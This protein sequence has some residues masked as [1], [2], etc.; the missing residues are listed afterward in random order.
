MPAA[1]SDCSV[2]VV[3][4]DSADVVGGCL[5]SIPAECEVVVVD[6]ASSDG[7]AR[8]AAR[9]RPD[10][11]L[12][13]MGANRGFAAGCNAGVGASTRPLVLL[14][15][16]D[17]RLEPDA[18]DT[19]CTALDRHPGAIVGPAVLDDAGRL[20]HAVRRPSAPLHEVL[21]LFP[22][23]G[24]LIPRS[25][26]RNLPPDAPRYREGGPVAYLQ[27]ACLL[28]ARA[29]WEE[30][31]G[32]DEDFFLYSEE[33]TLAWRAWR[34]GHPS[35]YVPGARVRHTWGTSTA[36]RSY[37]AERHQYRSR[38]LFY[39][40]RDGELRGR[41]SALLI[42]AALIVALALRPALRLLG[43]GT[44]RPVGWYASALRGILEGL[45]ARR[46]S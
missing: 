24:R 3:V 42:A 13:D 43:A 41:A 14:L 27:G 21:E 6:N 38:A 39:R 19:L 5:A 25:R 17:A 9:M 10:A 36:K 4:H 46:T 18:L 23:T 26:A 1:P 8:V 7:G 11:R 44:S 31:G 29:T 20:R 15:N 12:V 16:P 22:V 37:F 30:L 2:I 32:L 35:L 40:K 45:V 33:E 34:A 28:L